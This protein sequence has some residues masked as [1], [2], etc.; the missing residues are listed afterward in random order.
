MAACDRPRSWPDRPQ[1]IGLEGALSIDHVAAAHVAGSAVGGED[2]AT[3]GGIGGE[4]WGGTQHQR[5]AESEKGKKTTHGKV[6][7]KVSEARATDT[8]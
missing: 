5:Q 6:R 1:G 7:R 8:N 2:L 3:V 4:T